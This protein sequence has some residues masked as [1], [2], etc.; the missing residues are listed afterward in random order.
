MRT[1]VGL[2][3]NA[4]KKIDAS[5]IKNEKFDKFQGQLGRV[6]IRSATSP[7]IVDLNVPGDFI[8]D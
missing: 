3:V 2:K 7:A 4:G 1:S 6:T 8:K 5:F